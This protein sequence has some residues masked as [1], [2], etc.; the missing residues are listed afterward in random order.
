SKSM[1]QKELPGPPMATKQ[2]FCQALYIVNRK[3]SLFF[4][5]SRG[6]PRFS[7]FSVMSWGGGGGGGRAEKTE[8]G[9]V[10]REDPARTK[11]E[12]DVLEGGIRPTMRPDGGVSLVGR[13]VK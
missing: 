8:E 1:L 3:V 4:L 2:I 13:K 11:P 5:W 6:D 7:F 10:I 9:A 12:G